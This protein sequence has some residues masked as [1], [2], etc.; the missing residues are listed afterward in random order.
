M[1]GVLDLRGNN[2]D[3]KTI[4]NLD[5]KWDFERYSFKRNWPSNT[6][7]SQMIDIPHGWNAILNPDDQ[8]SFGYGTYHLRI[9]LPTE[10][11]Q[12]YSIR[13]PSVR[14][15][16]MLYVNGEL[17]GQSDEP[18]TKE[19]E[20]K[21]YNLPYSTSFTVPQDGIVDIVMF[22]ANFKDT[23]KSGIVRSLHFGTQEAVSY[24]T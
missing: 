21:A 16:S 18:A 3:E 14:S 19:N 24:N 10:E 12:V 22:V 2:F 9:L 4:I 17:L 11:K 5:G 6:S 7:S 20:Y 23:R 13:V 1:Q 8:H 15:A